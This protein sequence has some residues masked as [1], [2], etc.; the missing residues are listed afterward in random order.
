M[1]FADEIAK[2]NRIAFIASIQL[3][4]CDS[5]LHILQKLIS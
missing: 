1:G 3:L 5:Q 2:S 4:W